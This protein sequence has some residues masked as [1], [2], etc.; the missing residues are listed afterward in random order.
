M[1]KIA[2]FIL[3]ADLARLGEQV[4]EVEAGADPIPWDGVDGHEVHLMGGHGL[5]PEQRS[6]EEPPDPGRLEDQ[7]A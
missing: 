6:A 1:V 2:L 3:S 7:L 4:Q 5:P